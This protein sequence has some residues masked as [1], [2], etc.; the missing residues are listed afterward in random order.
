[1]AV[2][3]KGLTI[4]FGG[5]TTELQGALKKVQGTAKDTQGALKDINRALK[6]DPGNTELLTEKAKLLNRAYGETK[7]K[8]DAYKSALAGLEEKQRSGAALTEREQAQYSSLKAQIAICENQLESYADDLKNVSREAEASK[9]GLYQFGQTIQDNSDKLA[10]AGKGLET[11]GKTITGAVGGAA[12]ALVGLASSQEENIEQTHQ[13]D[14]AWKDAGG[15]SEQAR[16]SYTL[17]YKLLGE[18]DTATEAAQNLSRLTTNQQELD[19]WTNIAAGSF[20]KFG[21]ALPLENLVEASQ[22]TAH[23]GT[24]TGGLADALNWATASNEQWSAA[25]SGNQAAQQAFNDQLDQGATK[26]DAFNAALAACGSEQERSTLITQ[27]LDGLYGDI[28]QTYQETNKTMLDTREQQ[29]QLNQKMAEAGEA[30]MPLKEKVLELGTT[31]LE[32]VTPALEG[33]SNW[34][35]Q[36]S[37]EQQDLVTNIGLGTLAFGGLATGAGKVLQ[38]G[39]EIGGAIKGVSETFGGLKGAIGAVGGGWTL[40][41]GLIAANPILLGVA[42]VAA[43]VAGLTWFF[44]QT[45]AG[46]QLWSDFTGWISEKWQGV[47]NFF[48]G[49]PAFWQGVWDGITGKCEEVK[50][51]LADKFNGIQ[52]SA[53]NAWEGLKS[54]ASDTW[55]N[56]QTAAAEKFGAIRDSIQN[57][58]QTAQT[59][60]SS[61]AGALQSVLNG[62]WEQARNQASNAFDAIRD[63]ISTKL[64]NAQTNA[65]NAGNAIGDKLGFPGLGSTVANKFNEIKNNITSPI[66]DAWNVI[67]GIPGRISSAFSGI[68][69]SL[70]HINLPHFN[71][72]WRDVGG[73]VKLP[74]VSVDWYA[75]GGYFDR[76][77]IIGVGEAGGEHVTPDKKLRSSVE[78]AVSRAFDRVGAGA[79]RAVEIA[80][81]VNASVSDKLD[82]YTTGQ[83]IGAGIASRLKQKG[84]TVGA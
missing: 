28:G 39:T 25:L 70:P 75:K 21:D 24:V 78:D 15:T 2:T 18:E 72:S 48:A 22:E 71:V 8:L 31:L 55:S 73:V 19:Q 49:V 66:N 84:V 42:A 40:F 80:V 7:A 36:L 33:V 76:P 14:A 1:M 17:F 54:T 26:E 3:Y 57:D 65:I 10:K 12:T 53:S 6:L 81:T 61:A 62:D 50:N 38:T 32:K 67:S 64:Q 41:T 47:Q 79:S 44:T 58:M 34:Y 20:S 9:T 11:T 13:L 56:L 37:P 69:I 16:N 35:Q 30:A 51:S 63:N 45:E 60:G 43:A 29:A 74:S 27:T 59:V 46:K 82:A 4:K 52:Q 5:D 77:S 83:Q 68:R 23:T